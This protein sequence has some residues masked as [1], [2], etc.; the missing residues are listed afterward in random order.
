MASARRHGAVDDEEIFGGREAGLRVP[1]VVAA[2]RRIAWGGFCV[3]EQGE[4]WK[5]PSEQ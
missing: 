3:G 1:D 4:K 5:V 2:V